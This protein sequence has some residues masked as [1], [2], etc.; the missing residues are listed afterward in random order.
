VNVRHAN[1]GIDG[2]VGVDKYML[3]RLPI[4]TLSLLVED[5]GPQN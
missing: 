1:D 5:S 2:C 4:F 3:R